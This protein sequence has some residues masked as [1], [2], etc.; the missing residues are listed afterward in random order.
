MSGSYEWQGACAARG[1]SVRCAV[2]LHLHCGKWGN[3][4]RRRAYSPRRSPAIYGPFFTAPLRKLFAKHSALSLPATSDKIAVH[5]YVAQRRQVPLLLALL[6]RVNAYALL[7]P[8]PATM[9]CLCFPVRSP[10][11]AWLRPFCAAHTLF[12]DHARQLLRVQRNMQPSQSRGSG[13]LYIYILAQEYLTPSM[14]CR[15]DCLL[16]RV[17][18]N[19]W[20]LPTTKRR[21]STREAFV[22]SVPRTCK[23]RAV[24]SSP[25]QPP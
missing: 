1:L 9:I 3:A 24:E 25:L 7:R 10:T 17:L 11:G 4:N 15:A 2:F 16:A 18:R 12:V 14:T 6:A 5:T 22:A 21:R 8:L 19:T 13:F 23:C 20:P